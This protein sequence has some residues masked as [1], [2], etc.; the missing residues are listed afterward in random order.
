MRYIVWKQHRDNPERFYLLGAG[1]WA[2]R[3]DAAKLYTLHGARSV[4][5]RMQRSW[6]VELE[7]PKR[8]GF[9]AVENAK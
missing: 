6:G 5:G 3:P 1:V 4:L 7:Q 9:Y 2:D 8:W